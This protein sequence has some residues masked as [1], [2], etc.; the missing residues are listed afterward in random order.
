MSVWWLGEIP[1][2]GWA[3]WTRDEFLRVSDQW[4]H[5][6][7]WSEATDGHGHIYGDHARRALVNL[8]HH[9]AWRFPH[10]P[11]SH[12]RKTL[13]TFLVYHRL[14]GCEFSWAAWIEPLAVWIDRLAKESLAGGDVWVWQAVKDEVRRLQAQL[15]LLVASHGEDQAL[16]K[17]AA[18]LR[19][20]LD[21]LTVAVPT[22]WNTV[23]EPPA[24]APLAEINPDEW[25][26]RRHGFVSSLPTPVLRSD[27]VGGLTDLFPA[28]TP[29]VDTVIDV[30][31]RTA[32]VLPT[33]SVI[34]VAV[35]PH[36][37]MT[38][39]TTDVRI[40]WWEA[41]AAASPLD[42]AL[43]DPIAL[44]AVTVA[45]WGHLIEHDPKSLGPNRRQVLGRL[46]QEREVLALA[47]AWLWLENGEPDLVLSW[48]KA[49]V[50]EDQGRWL[51]A[52]M[53]VYPGYWLE[54]ERVRQRVQEEMA[55]IADVRE[56]PGWQKGPYVTAAHT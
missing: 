31:S 49:Y 35:G 55:Q 43:A 33:P 8:L 52:R 12:V 22:L 42:W 15:E 14:T 20:R 13:E 53:Q 9:E 48:L 4:R 19:S 47:D 21:A 11:L 37:L 36:A 50:G 41:A 18:A 56:W 28:K 1:P 40:W 54:R 34:K 7:R 38:R 51:I 16:A 26:R 39:F 2:P 6:A 3:P 24:W 46:I 32:W 10:I 17:A 27:R 23:I 25:A 5:V 44:E 29:R 30:M 45:A